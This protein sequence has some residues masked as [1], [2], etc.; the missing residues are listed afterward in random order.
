MLLSK[1]VK[2][3]TVDILNKQ[4][5]SGQS[6]KVNW[7]NIKKTEASNEKK[8]NFTRS[9]DPSFYLK[10]LIDDSPIIFSQSLGK[11]SN[12]NFREQ[13]KVIFLYNLF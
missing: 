12:Q 6:S 3:R 8:V 7:I 9:Y 13:G 4:M 11:T 5:N 10:K 1:C 2:K